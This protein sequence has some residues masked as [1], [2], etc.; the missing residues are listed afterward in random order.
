MFADSFIEILRME[1]FVPRLV[2]QF[3]FGVSQVKLT[4]AIYSTYQHEQTII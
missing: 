1:Q 4:A 3:F 2:D